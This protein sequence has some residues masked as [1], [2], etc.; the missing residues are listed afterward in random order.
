MALGPKW[1][2]NCPKM[3]FGVIGHFLL[4]GQFFP[5][6]GFWPVFHSM[7]GGLT[8][9]PCGITWCDRFWLNLQLGVTEGFHIRQRMLAAQSCF[10]SL[11]LWSGRPPN[12]T[13]TQKEWKWP[14]SDSKVTQAD[15]PQSDPKVTQKWLKNDS[16][17]GSGVTF[18]SI[19]GHFGVG[20]PESL[21]SHF[22]VTLIL[23]VFLGS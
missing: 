1:G 14:K 18:E 11:M 13:E 20:L 10:P 17:M 23:S 4:F 2:R 22:W 8:R 15:R 21:L 9:N 19:L 5:I 7:P 3:G 16:K 12:S 6:F